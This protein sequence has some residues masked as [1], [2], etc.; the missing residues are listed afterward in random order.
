MRA[1]FDMFF[2]KQ[3]EASPR[4]DRFLGFLTKC[5]P[6]FAVLFLALT[7]AF[8]RVGGLKEIQET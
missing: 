3:A 2:E 7:K 8:P 4:N 6:S 1:S 5:L